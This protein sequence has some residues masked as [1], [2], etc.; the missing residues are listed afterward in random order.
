MSVLQT[1]PEKINQRRAQMLVHSCL[2]YW[3][4]ETVVSDHKWQEWAEDLVRLQEENKGYS[5]GFYD[6]VFRDW[7]GSTGCHLPKDEWVVDKAR[8][9]LRYME[10]TLK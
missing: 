6:A 2:Y 10:G 4:D 1:L 3:M 8:K 9:V 7:N 5:T